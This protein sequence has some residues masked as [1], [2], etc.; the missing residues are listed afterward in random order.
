MTYDLV[1][2]YGAY[3]VVTD[4]GE[5]DRTDFIMSPRALLLNGYLGFENVYCLYVIRR[6][7]TVVVPLELLQQLKALVF[8]LSWCDDKCLS[9]VTLLG[10]ELLGVLVAAGLQVLQEKNL[11]HR[12]LKPQNLLLATISAT[13]LMKIGDFGF[14]R[15]LTPLQLADT[16]CGSPYYMAPGIIQSHMMPRLGFIIVF[17]SFCHCG[18]H[19]WSCNY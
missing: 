5:G 13:P 19:G 2:D 15:S 6:I 3:V 11:I 14:A 17:L 8:M 16:L 9:F 18:I 4:Y 1:T 12:D 10:V 7:E